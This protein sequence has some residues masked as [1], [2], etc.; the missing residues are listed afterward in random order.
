[1]PI[2]RSSTFF[3]RLDD[4][5]PIKREDIIIGATRIVVG[6]FRKL[7][8]SDNLAAMTIGVYGDPWDFH[9]T[10]AT[11]GLH[12]IDVWIGSIAFAF[13]IYLDF[14]GYTDIARGV[15][16]LFGWEFE[17]NFLYPMACR[18]ISDHWARWHISFT[19]WIRD[20]IFIPLGGSRR[21]ELRTYIN[22]FITW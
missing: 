15:A 18:N 11:R 16:R 17:I 5:L 1:G 7:V 9:Q 3:S 22:I 14:A 2:V 21:G 19:T 8:L 13:Q 12:P 20:Y 6:F 10:W 4:R